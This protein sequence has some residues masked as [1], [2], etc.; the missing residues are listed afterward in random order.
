MRVKAQTKLSEVHVQLIK[1]AHKL[2]QEVETRWDS[3]Y[4]IFQHLYKHCCDDR[5]EVGL[6]STSQEQVFGKTIPLIYPGKQV[7][8]LT[9]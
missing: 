5:L 4:F 7:I 3:T 2:I 1:P 8:S 6:I 9:G